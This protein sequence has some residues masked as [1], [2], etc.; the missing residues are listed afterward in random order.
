MVGGV[1]GD[2]FG[3]RRVYLAALLLLTAALVW[4][5]VSTALWMLYVF[6]V[7]FGIGNGGWFP[8]IPVLAGRIFGNRHIGTIFAA[9]L[10]GAGVGAVVGPI[11]AGYVFDVTGSYKIAFIVAAGTA[12]RGGRVDRYVEGSP[13]SGSVARSLLRGAG[14]LK[15]VEWRRPGPCYV[16]SSVDFGGR[17]RRDCRWP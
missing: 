7:A 13:A 4:L 11:V 2:R 10:L 6:A 17:C 16:R 1:L 12:F 9:L 14:S 5:T 8:Q 15:R 3:A